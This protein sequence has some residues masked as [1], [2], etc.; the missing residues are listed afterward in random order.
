[1]FKASYNAV[2]KRIHEEEGWVMVLKIVRSAHLM[3]LMLFSTL[4][5]SQVDVGFSSKNLISA[6]AN[7]EYLLY[8]PD[9]YD[10]KPIPLVFSLHGSG[11]APQNQVNTSRFDT[12]ADR[13]GFVAAF[14]AGEFTNSVTS[15][16]WNAN[17]EAGV[18]DVQFVRDMIED[19]AGL[20]NID[21][22]RIYISGFSGGGRMSSRLACELSDVLAAAAPVAGLQYPDDCTLNRPIPIISFHALDD[23]VNQYMVSQNSRPYWRMGVET[24]LDKWR[25]A[26]GCA[27]S[28]DT[29][30]LSASVS[31]Y[32]WTECSGSVEIQFYQR[33]TG[34]HAWPVADANANQGIDASEL[35]WEFFNQHKL[36]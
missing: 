36:P 14:P 27:Q 9:G 35:I 11:G 26:N 28:N 6:G 5:I 10:G 21:R 22:S 19:V 33:K 1:L 25:Q 29:D 16:S 3:V 20:V 32:H 24:A 7:R 13:Y 17:N 2:A 23:R 30:R 12:L 31:T 15:R 8:I 18:D 34:G 4:V